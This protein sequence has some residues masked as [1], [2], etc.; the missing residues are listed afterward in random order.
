M[1]DDELDSLL[2]AAA[3]RPDPMADMLARDLAT[4][5]ASSDRA[6]ESR[7]SRPRR[8]RLRRPFVLGGAA[9]GVLVLTASMTGSQWMMSVPP[10]MTLQPGVQR[11]YEPI[12]F[13]ATWENGVQRECQLF[14]EFERLD[15]EELDRVAAHVRAKDWS[16][17]RKDLSDA[18]T[19]D[20]AGLDDRIR[21]EL[22]SVVPDLTAPFESE[23]A[24][25]LAGY[26]TSCEGVR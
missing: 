24:P 2:R 19:D 21:G 8:K 16:A 15:D 10:F 9:V 20:S 7:R 26:G 18:A 1:Y 13:V 5:V 25:V 4:T 17:W 3:P 6:A 11:V 23:T 12:E 22:R 14:L